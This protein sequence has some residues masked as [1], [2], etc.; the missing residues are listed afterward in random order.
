MYRYIFMIFQCVKFKIRL[1]LSLIH[2]T[3]QSRC[4][5]AV[6]SIL[7]KLEPMTNI[8]KK[9][10]CKN[11]QE[12]SHECNWRSVFKKR[13]FLLVALIDAVFTA[14]SNIS[15]VEREKHGYRCSFGRFFARI[16]R[17][18]WKMEKNSGRSFRW[19]TSSFSILVCL[20]KRN[21]M[22]NFFHFFVLDTVKSITSCTNSIR[23]NQL[24]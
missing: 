21:R 13:S 14:T 22:L 18:C 12:H 23:I 5:H 10:Y 1:Y 8:A 3:D 2:T 4:S 11:G 6:Q 20:G 16:T 7:K 19:W 24:R 9:Y 17:K 15:P